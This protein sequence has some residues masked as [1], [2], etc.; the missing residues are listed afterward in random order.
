M[1]GIKRKGTAEK[2]FQ[3]LKKAIENARNND[4]I[5]LLFLLLAYASEKM[6]DKEFWYLFGIADNKRKE[7]KKAQNIKRKPIIIYN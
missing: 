6:K 5:E 1:K 3:E 2:P 7:F 4:E